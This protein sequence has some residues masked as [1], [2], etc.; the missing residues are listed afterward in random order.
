MQPGRHDDLRG[1][2]GG[3]PGSGR[4]IDGVERLIAD[5]QPRLSTWPLGVRRRLSRARHPA[6]RAAGHPR[7]KARSRSNSSRGRNL[8]AVNA[9]TRGSRNGS[10]GAHC[11]RHRGSR[12][13]DSTVVSGGHLAVLVGF[14]YHLAR[15][16]FEII[17]S[18]EA[19][20]D[21][22]LFS[23]V[24]TRESSRRDRGALAAPAD[25]DQ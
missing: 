17:L 16:A 21:L 22:R 18:P 12:A 7:R 24:R 9:V 10:T 8:S 13:G 15:M 19:I 2:L 3:P 11:R 23:A 1:L 6:I 5:D 25:Q 4:R 20:E 14:G